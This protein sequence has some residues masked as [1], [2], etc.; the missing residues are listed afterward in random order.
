MSPTARHSLSGALQP[1]RGYCQT[2]LERPL[3]EPSRGLGGQGHCRPALRLS[4]FSRAARLLGKSESTASLDSSEEQSWNSEPPVQTGLSPSPWR[5]RVWGSLTLGPVLCSACPLSAAPKS[6]SAPSRHASKPLPHPT[7]SRLSPEAFSEN[8]KEL[9]QNL[10]IR[11][12][13]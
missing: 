3:F 1:P 11:L 6:L 4:P 7:S 9:F 10:S 13:P 12:L 5:L 8:R 2:E